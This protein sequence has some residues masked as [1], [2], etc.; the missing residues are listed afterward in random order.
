MYVNHNLIKVLKT[1]KTRFAKEETQMANKH[2]K[3]CLT[4]CTMQIK[5]TVRGRPSGAVVKFTCP[6]LA[7]Q[8]L[9]VLIPA[10]DMPP[11]IKP[12]CG[13][14]PTYKVEEDRHRC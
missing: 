3:R 6:T 11:L 1:K 9:S 5:T 14:H 7:A 10:V 12:R 8:G 2:M 4:S 13:R